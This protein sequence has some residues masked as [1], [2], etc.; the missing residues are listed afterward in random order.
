M[1]RNNSNSNTYITENRIG[2]ISIFLFIC[3]ILFN[4]YSLSGNWNKKLDEPHVFRQTQ[5]AISTYYL[6]NEKFT[7]NYI[8]PVF[9]PPYTIPIEFPIYQFLVAGTNWVTPFTLD[10]TGRLVSIICLW[11]TLL[12][13]YITLIKL[14]GIDN[15]AA[16]F[17]ISLALINPTLLFWQSTFL[18][19]TCNILFAS[20]WLYFYLLWNKNPS[21]IK[22]I[23]MLLLGGVAALMKIT[24]F[25][26]WAILGFFLIYLFE[27]SKY[28]NKQ[29]TL[30]TIAFI[31][32]IIL[33]LCWNQYTDYLKK[34]NVFGI[35][36]SS[37]NHLF[38]WIVWW[39]Y[40]RI[41][42][43]VWSGIVEYSMFLF[44]IHL[45]LLLF[46][47]LKFWKLS[48]I[49]LVVFWLGPFLFTRLY[50]HHEY[51]F[52]V[53]SIFL[54]T[55]LGLVIFSLSRSKHLYLSLFGCAC[56]LLVIYFNIYK[57]NYYYK[58]KVVQINT[59]IPPIVNLIKNNVQDN[60]P[61]I[62]FGDDWNPCIPY[63]TNKKA[64]MVKEEWITA[65]NYK[66]FETLVIRSH[67]KSI[68]CLNHKIADF[69]YG[70]KVANMLQIDTIVSSKIDQW[71]YCYI[72]NQSK[73]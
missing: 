43:T 46:Y 19:E 23:F 17:C 3:A 14:L 50:Y 38:A 56:V 69:K 20:L 28:A 67:A 22:Y 49:L 62:I 4:V 64:I 54:S 60:C 61:I 7:L 29:K 1:H 68:V 52:V 12:I 72:Y 41:D 51:Y 66:E 65:S 59:A 53:G 10:Q 21:Q 40:G 33:C 32:P 55:S 18:P 6:I 25:L 63:Y 31:L 73:K 5:T 48:V 57:Y 70:I 11:C 36:L 35:N 44:K 15:Y 45:P 24:T 27:P 9:G 8:T 39:D 58:P 71:P 2:N 26:N 42:K 13:W 47:K 16:L 34:T 37:E 30:N